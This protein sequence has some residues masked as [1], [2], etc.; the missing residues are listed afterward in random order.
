[1]SDSFILP[2]TRLN[3]I[4]ELLMEEI[5]QSKIIERDQPI[6]WS[7]QHIFS[8]SQ[9]S[10]LLAMSRKEDIEIAGIAGAIHDIAIIRTGKFEN[11]GPEGGPMVREFLVSFNTRY[12]NQI[13]RIEQEEIELIVQATINHTDKTNFTENYFDELIKDADSL[14]RYLHG[15]ETY[16]FYIE[17]CTN[18]L[19]DLHLDNVIL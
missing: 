18:A 7:I 9:L 19:A 1:M 13:G 10:K 6:S 2:N 4:L 14:D 3:K 5:N 17:R 15:K 12:G 11:H 16:D 8:C